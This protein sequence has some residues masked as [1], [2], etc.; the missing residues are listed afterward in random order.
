MNCKAG[1]QL[2]F[3]RSFNSTRIYVLSF[4]LRFEMFVMFILGKASVNRPHANKLA[5]ESK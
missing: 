4:G 1:T 2:I 3:Q 5:E